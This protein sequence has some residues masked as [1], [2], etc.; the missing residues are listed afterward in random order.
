MKHS[1]A[2]AEHEPVAEHEP[3]PAAAALLFGQG[4]SQIR[5]FAA[6]LFDRGEQLGL[7]G[8]LEPARL[9]SRHLLNSVLAAPFLRG[10]VAD[11]GSGGGFPGIPLAIARPEIALTLIEPMERRI[12]WL[13]E[14]VDKLELS[15]V[16]VVRAR[17]EDYEPKGAF[18]Q[19]TARA[20]SALSKLIPVTAPLLKPGGEMLFLKGHSVDQEILKAEKIMK[21]FGV[22]NPR[23]Q[24]IGGEHGT[25]ST[26]LFTAKFRA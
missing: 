10:T 18:D 3:E 8:P 19:V 21:R 15:N 4:I 17:A 14:Q 11:I 7:I 23:V 24:E 20:V 5:S 6:D 9:W 13:Q 16:T 1:E 22:T 25:E 2:S 26:K 12:A